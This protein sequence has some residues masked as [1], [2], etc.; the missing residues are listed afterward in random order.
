MMTAK[1]NCSSVPVI[2][3]RQ[4]MMR[5]LLDIAQ[6]SRSMT[7]IPKRETNRKAASVRRK[8]RG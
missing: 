7:S 3:V 6:A 8:C 4:G 2:T 1:T 5:R